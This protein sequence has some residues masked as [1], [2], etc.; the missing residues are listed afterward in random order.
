MG[1]LFKPT[2]EVEKKLDL[3]V[4]LVRKMDYDGIVREFGTPLEVA[5]SVQRSAFRAPEGQKFVVASI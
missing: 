1:N 2:K 4:D 3:A 5:A